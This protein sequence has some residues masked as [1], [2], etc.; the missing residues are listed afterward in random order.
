MSI[1]DKIEK[2]VR[3]RSLVPRSAMPAL[4]MAISHP[5]YRYQLKR[6]KKG[7]ARFG[8]QYGT[9]LLFVAGL[10][11]S[12]TT[13][14]ERMLASI[15]GFSELML[16]EAVAYEQ[17]KGESHSYDFPRG[18]RKRFDKALIV[19]K[20]HSHG[21]DSN[22]AVL[23]EEA[24]PF[25][26]VYRDLRDVA[27]S[28]VHYVQCTPYHP[29]NPHFR[30]LDLK[31]ALH[32][33]ARKHLS[34]YV[35]WI[36]SWHSREK[37]PLCHA[38]AYEKMLASPVTEFSKVVEHYGLQLL[39]SQVKEIVEANSFERLSGGREAGQSDEKSFFRKAVAG[40]WKNHFDEA[41]E[42][43]YAT[44]MDKLKIDTYRS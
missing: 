3:Q 12:G 27:V 43:A 16:P 8:D 7:F 36:N 15:P 30:S 11:K 26:V 17:R 5:R 33:F 39:P 10:P 6:G 40:D 38:I 25:V 29:D 42:K 28:Y 13:W 18:L 24:L 32:L 22:M 37:D 35:D 14:L 34:E 2:N 19:L 31:E 21:S 4:K 41:L 9:N 20:L 44:E 1:F 23:H